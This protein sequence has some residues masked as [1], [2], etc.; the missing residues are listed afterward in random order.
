MRGRILFSDNDQRFVRVRS[1][2][3]EARGYEVIPSFSVEEATRILKNEYV[4]LAIMDI[5]MTNDDDDRDTSGLILA[6]APAFRA[7][8]KIILTG[9][10][11]YEAVRDALGPEI[12]GLPPAVAF[13]AKKEG[14][15]AMLR[16][17]DEAFDTFVKIDRNLR[18]IVKKPF[19]F[20][21]LI[22]LVDAGAGAGVETRAAELEDLFRRLFNG[23]H[24][25]TVGRLLAQATE[26]LLLEVFAFDEHGA[27]RS[28]VVACGK[29]AK[30]AQ[31]RSNYDRFA[32]ARAGSDRIKRRGFAEST[33]YALTI[34]ELLD[35]DLERIRPF[36]IYFRN[37][38]AQAVNEAL[39]DLFREVSR[40]AGPQDRAV[41]GRRRTVSP[42][43][44]L[45][46]FS[47]PVI[48][49]RIE[50]LCHVTPALQLNSGGRELLFVMDGRDDVNLPNPATAF[51]AVDRLST[52]RMP[53]GV[54]HGGVNASNV[55]VDPAGK[56]WPLNY[57][58]VR[59]G[60]VYDDFASLEA[61][62]RFDLIDCEDLAARYDMEN[63]LVAVADTGHHVR[64]DDLD[65]GIEKAVR[66]TNHIRQLAGGEKEKDLEAYLMRL[67]LVTM[68]KIASF[69]PK[70]K[71]TRREL[72]PYQ[73]ALLSA[74]LLCQKLVPA[75]AVPADLPDEARS[76]VW[77]DAVN[78]AV[79]VEGSKVELTDLEYDALRC[80]HAYRNRLCSRRTISEEVYGD[81]YDESV[82]EEDRKRMERVRVDSLISRLRR[83]MGDDGRRQKYI[84]TVR[85][86]GYRLEIAS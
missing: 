30:I 28:R 19:S 3:L 61:T 46:A 41:Y 55:L 43:E 66:V 13:L 62:V 8:P 31:E 1:E 32:K 77:P 21:Q 25:I 11:T 29:C 58:S 81:S 70:H 84:K 86:K 67:L 39:G 7:I 78:Q 82:S 35:G 71:H 56:T 14:P 52:Y 80:L 22:R 15:E 65:C 2:F 79:W 36:E 12:D 59:E 17:V 83:K 64:T 85:G 40:P 42:L 76:S 72:L 60:P 6:R 5:R 54:I 24:Q 69:D 9:F 48:A 49:Q 18:T 34:Y 16:A 44:G 68:R 23:D 63:R 4:H 51:L 45:E 75:P 26:V 10:P 57:A 73:H 33:R 50:A 37:Q 47:Q 38:A 27:Y 74:A 53:C 20:E